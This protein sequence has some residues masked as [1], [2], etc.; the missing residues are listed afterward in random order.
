[1][2]FLHHFL[3]WR[4][5]NLLDFAVNSYGAL[6][7]RKGIPLRVLSPLRFFLRIIS[8]RLLPRYL[9]SP[10]KRGIYTESRKNDLVN[11]KKIIVSLTS[12]P[13]RISTVWMVI[14]CMLRQTIR[15]DKI[16]L[17]LSRK[18]FETDDCVPKSL[19]E[20]QNDVFKIVFVKEDYRSHKK[21]L[22]VFQE[23]PNDIVITV[24][25]DIFYPTTMIETLCANYRKYPNAVICRYAKKIKRNERGTLSP[26]REWREIF[27]LYETD[28]FFGSGGG[29]LFVPNKL[30]KDVT[31]AKLATALCP[32]ADDIWLNAMARLNGLSLVP[33][34]R[35]LILP[36]FSETKET[37]KS[38]NV[39]QN[40]NDV[41]IENVN[42]YYKKDVFER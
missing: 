29:T 36:I 21:Y 20:L 11:E 41:Q 31:N 37:L 24:D 13:G 17:Y 7:N 32:L 40:L 23:H 16:I 28:C 38:I 15:P 4:T 14:E 3:F 25:D 9:A 27:K 10:R 26:Y 34:T 35:N 1:M 5:M 22:Y 6:H 8:N 12:F 33:I 39:N 18:Q 2:P 19:M 30:F 42:K